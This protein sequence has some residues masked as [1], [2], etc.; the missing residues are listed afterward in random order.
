MSSTEYLCSLHD[1][2]ADWHF[3]TDVIGVI[4][5]LVHLDGS[6]EP[7]GLARPQDR[8][9]ALANGIEPDRLVEWPSGVAPC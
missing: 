5:A 1:E 8:A 2:Q 3:T 4:P 9:C 6:W 7:L